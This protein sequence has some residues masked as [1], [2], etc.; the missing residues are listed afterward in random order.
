VPAAAKAGR[1]KAG[2]QRYAQSD[3]KM[4]SSMQTQT[5][6]R[7]VAVFG[8]NGFVGVHLLKQLAEE[9]CHCICISRSGVMPVHLRET[10]ASWLNRVDWVPGD[11]SR[12]DVGLL[13]GAEAV[14]TLVG[15]PPVPTFSAAAKQRQVFMNGNTNVGAINGAAQAG[16][17]RVV[18]LSAHIPKP[19]RTARFGYFVGKQRAFDAAQTFARLS[20]HHDATIVRPTAIYGTRYTPSGTPIP[21]ETLM[22]PIANIQ[23]AFPRFIRKRLPEPL[24]SVRQ[25]ALVLARAALNRQWVGGK[26]TLV[27]NEEILKA[28]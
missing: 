20:P 28:R 12:P 4:G 24:V 21:L 5:A 27:E 13:V 10:S 17:K 16:V 26:P 6:N 18:L 11:A 22:A 8:G 2:A 23:L 15:S 14:V 7:T 3:K 25:V 19:L 9:G 1:F